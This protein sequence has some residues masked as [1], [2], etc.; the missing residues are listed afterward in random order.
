MP[1]ARLVEGT[2]ASLPTLADLPSQNLN[3]KPFRANSK[4]QTANFLNKPLART[5]KKLLR[6][7]GQEFLHFFTLP[8]Q[9]LQK[10]LVLE[11]H[12]NIDT[13]RQIQF[14]Q[15]IDGFRRRLVNVDNAPM[16]AGFKVFP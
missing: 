7:K 16:G 9:L 8:R 2:C 1:F 6:G 11:L 10:L 12:F 13:R 14:H 4:G 3:K 15:G 5:Q